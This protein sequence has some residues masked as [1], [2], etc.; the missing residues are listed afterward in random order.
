MDKP[1]AW[2]N[3]YSLL[4]NMAIYS[5]FSHEKWWF[6]I[7]MLVYQRVGC[8]GCNPWLMMLQTLPSLFSAVRRQSFGMCRQV[9]EWQTR[10]WMENGHPPYPPF[11][12]LQKVMAMSWQPIDSPRFQ[13]FSE[14]FLLGDCFWGMA[15][16]HGS[17]SDRSWQLCS[18]VWW[19]HRTNWGAEGERG[20]PFRVIWSWKSMETVRFYRKIICGVSF[21]TSHG[22]R[23]RCFRLKF[24]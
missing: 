11:F 12:F 20:I 3:V 6:S 19:R 5:E 8:L 13:W 21:S 18:W 1:A 22:P 10:R 23:M 4:L 24:Y 14:N 2:V 16:A 15:M 17:S 7:V 9:S